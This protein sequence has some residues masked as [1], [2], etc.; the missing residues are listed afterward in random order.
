MMT[1]PATEE[2]KAVRS[3]SRA[4]GFTLLELLIALSIMTAAM[5]IVVSTFVVT[6][7]AR[8]RGSDLLEELHHGDFV[9][10]QLV[11]SLRSIAFFHN[12]PERYGFW[13]EDREF[14]GYPA[15]QISF[16]AIFKSAGD[17][18]GLSDPEPK[19]EKFFGSGH[20]KEFSLWR[21]TL[22]YSIPTILAIALA[23][24]VFCRRDL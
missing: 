13:L 10:E 14:A 16:D 4:R 18:V 2:N 1:A 9:M 24:F 12:K 22:G 23:T 15:D 5:A 11:S 20:F 7:R 19:E 17:I 8:Q 21:V 3:A 6:L